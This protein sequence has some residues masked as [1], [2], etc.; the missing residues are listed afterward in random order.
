MP[1]DQERVIDLLAALLDVIIALGFRSAAQVTGEC[2]VKSDEQAE[3]ACTLDCRSSISQFC[4]IHVRLR[5][6]TVS[7]L[8]RSCW[9][10]PP[11]H[12][13]VCRGSSGGEGPRGFP[14]RRARSRCRA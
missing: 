5:P 12:P 13:R 1:D 7:T 6:N 8:L 4:W 11:S 3:A 9:P 14:S 10:Q 2:V